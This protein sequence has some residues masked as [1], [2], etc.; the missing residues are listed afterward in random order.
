MGHTVLCI[1][2]K[3]LSV[4]EVLKHVMINKKIKSTEY[5]S[6][7]LCARNLQGSK[8]SADVHESEPKRPII[9]FLVQS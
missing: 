9:I 2:I 1:I 5:L 6:L 7:R 4:L 8:T 3:I